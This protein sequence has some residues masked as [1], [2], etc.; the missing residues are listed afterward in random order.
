MAKPAPPFGLTAFGSN[1]LTTENDGQVWDW[2][3]MNLVKLHQRPIEKFGIWVV[4]FSF[5][6]ATSVWFASCSF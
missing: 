4:T 2:N 5:T 1:S 6:S 3:A